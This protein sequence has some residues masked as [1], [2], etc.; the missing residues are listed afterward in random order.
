MLTTIATGGEKKRAK[1][2]DARPLPFITIPHGRRNAC[3]EYFP[4]PVVTNRVQ[5]RNSCTSW[6]GVRNPFFTRSFFLAF[7]CSS[8]VTINPDDLWSNLR[9]MDD[10]WRL[11][12]WPGGIEHA[13]L[14]PR[15]CDWPKLQYQ[16]PI[17]PYHNVRLNPYLQHRC[18]GPHPISFD[19]A[20]GPNRIIH[21]THASSSTTPLDPARSKQLAT[22][23]PVRQMRIQGV[24]EDPLPHFPWLIEVEN[25]RGITCG[26]VFD[27]IA[28]KFVEYVPEEEY[29]SWTKHRKTVAARSYHQRVRTPAVDPARPDEVPDGRGHHHDGLRRIDYMGAKVIFHGLEQA[30][31]MMDN[32]WFMYVGAS[33]RSN[34]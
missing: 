26:D 10:S 25:T 7:R 34:M 9:S 19:I 1:K 32:T 5:V 15:P 14:H 23:P 24:A 13:A 8:S 6:R 17:P 21:N 12:N 27:A 2:L 11:G 22:Y 31:A 29:N 16:L 4:Y 33:E 28:R 18:N 30:S 20:L 3:G